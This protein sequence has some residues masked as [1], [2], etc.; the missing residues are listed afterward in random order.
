MTTRTSPER[1]A[2]RVWLGLVALTLGSAWLGESAAS[3]CGSAKSPCK[4]ARVVLF[5]TSS[6]PPSLP[7]AKSRMGGIMGVII[8]S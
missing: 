4:S 7:V 6:A 2:T 8:C 1:Q 5:S 3:A